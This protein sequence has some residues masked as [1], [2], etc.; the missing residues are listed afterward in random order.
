MLVA[1]NQNAAAAIAAGIDPRPRVDVNFV[2][3]DE[4]LAAVARGCL[5]LDRCRDPSDAGCAA[6]NGNIRGSHRAFD[7]DQPR[8][9]VLDDELG[10][11][12]GAGNCAID[13]SLG[14]DADRMT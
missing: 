11:A 1:A 5:R 2:A 14:R 7:I 3:G 6:I 12:R 4:H 8:F 9:A 10:C 13:Q